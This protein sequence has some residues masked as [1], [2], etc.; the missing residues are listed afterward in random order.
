MATKLGSSV[1]ARELDVGIGSSNPIRIDE[2]STSRLV[3]CIKPIFEGIY[4]V[5]T[6]PDP[7]SDL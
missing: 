4:N 7:V 3:S 1:E 6:L 5:K 2:H